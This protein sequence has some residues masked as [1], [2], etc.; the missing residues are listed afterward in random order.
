VASTVSVLLGNGDGTL[1]PPQAFEAG[2]GPHGI[3][4]ADLNRDGMLDLAVA[5]LGAYP[6]RATTAAVLMGVGN[7]TFGSPQLY[8]AGRA[9]TGVAAADFNRDGSP[10]LAFSSGDDATLSVLLNTGNGTF[11]PKV[12]FGAGQS[13][14]SVSAGDFNRD[15]IPDLVVTDHWSDTVS[16]FRGIGD[17]SF[18]PRQVLGAGRNPAWVAVG[19]LT[20]DGL[21]DLAV[22]N[23]FSTTVSVLEGKTDGTFHAG[24]EFGAAAAPEKV[25]LA[26]FNG[27]GRPD[28]AVANYFA[29]S[30][31]VLFNT[32]G[33]AAP[34]PP[35]AAP[36][37]S[38]G[39]G[40]YA[41][42]Q[43]VTISVATAGATIHYTTDGSTP[44]TA[45]PVYTAP[46]AVTRSTTIRAMAA[47][48]GMVNSA[49][50]SATYTLQTATPAFTPPAGYY[51]LPQFVEISSATPDAVIYYTTDGTTPTTSSTRYTDPVLVL[52]TSTLRAIAVAPGWTPSAVGSAS[53]TILLQ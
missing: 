42:P 4:V 45:S 51:L 20:G 15:Q 8:D 32:T 23:W 38:P 28:M 9:L 44:T 14:K 34:P 25:V 26:D 6:S 39:G 1:Q 47:A 18:A 19:D 41:A 3:A 30:V 35:V 53:Y 31:S 29:A 12:S 22:G 37:F 13:P 21:Q 5:N 52:T 24:L 50:S 10:D 16:V 2:S 43:A 33:P 17:G 27:D 40:T 36:T 7:G 11:G 46:I 48:S 49:V